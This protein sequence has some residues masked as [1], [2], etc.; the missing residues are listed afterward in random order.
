MASNMDG[1]AEYVE[2]IMS[3]SILKPVDASKEKDIDCSSR[4][5]ALSSDSDSEAPKKK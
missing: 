1:D 4:K 5:R 3:Q 2:N